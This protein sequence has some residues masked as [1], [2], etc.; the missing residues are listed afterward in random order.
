MTLVARIA[1]SSALTSFVNGCGIRTWLL[2]SI[3]SMT[4]SFFIRRTNPVAASCAVAIFS[5]MLLLVSSRIAS[6]IGDCT[7]EKKLSVC[8]D[9]SS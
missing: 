9:P 3:T 5:S 2:N 8:L 6:A 4:S 1:R 7:A